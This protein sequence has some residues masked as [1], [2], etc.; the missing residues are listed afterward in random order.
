MDGGRRRQRVEGDQTGPVIRLG[1]ANVKLF[2]QVC[3]V[4]GLAHLHCQT[5]PLEVP[6]PDLTPSTPNPQ[7][8]RRVV[9]APA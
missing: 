6:Q 8:L 3:K 2:A 9:H 1:R 4:G 7:P 5:I